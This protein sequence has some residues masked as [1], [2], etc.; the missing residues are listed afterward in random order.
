MSAVYMVG[1]TRKKRVDSER[2]MEIRVDD[3]LTRGYKIKQQGKYSTKM[4]KK[5]FGSAPVHGFTFFFSL[6]G[7]ALF[8]NAA[9]LSAGGVWVVAILASLT[10][11]AYSWLAAEE[12]IITVEEDNASQ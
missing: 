11:A 7:A 5:D 2:K 4:K 10:Y 1:M 3:F 6:L 8:F 9:G 12:V